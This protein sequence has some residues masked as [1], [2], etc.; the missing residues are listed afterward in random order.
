MLSLNSFHTFGLSANA[1][2]LV[3][4]TDVDQLIPAEP[5]YILGEGSNTIFLE[6][7]EGCI[8][9]VCLKGVEI[10]EH[11]DHYMVRVAA[12]ENWHQLVIHLL[13]EKIFGLENLALIPGTVGAAPIQNIGAYGRELADFCHSVETLHLQNGEKTAIAAVDCQFGYR[14]SIFKQSEA[15][16]LLITHV[17]LRFDKEWKPHNQ[18]GELQALGEAPSP[19]EIYNKVV[20]VRQSKLPDP[21][22]VG[23]A[24]SFFKNPVVEGDL[25]RLLKAKWAE[26]PGYSQEGGRVKIPAAWL[27]DTLG[28][29]GKTVG[30]IACHAKQPL[31]LIN[32]NHGTGQ[33]LLTLARDIRDSV[34][35]EFG[36][37]LENEVRLMGKLG[38]ITL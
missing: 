14:D 2:N 16:A 34:Y 38:L 10:T 28:F 8:L 4:L 32:Q 25:F 33:E 3:R 35:R 27:I 23:N 7:Y 29:K 13:Q 20:E 6:D 37:V 24:G 9:Q 26:I 11:N 18:Y 19:L 5:F 17:N 1:K 22:K 30:G 15:L 31:V 12:G 21:A 36:I